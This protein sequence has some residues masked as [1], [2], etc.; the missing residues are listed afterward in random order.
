M[1]FR[2]F[3]II[4]FSISFYSNAENY[5]AE[6]FFGIFT[7]GDS[8]AD[9]ESKNKAYGEGLID[10]LQKQGELTGFFDQPSVDLFK[11]EAAAQCLECS[12]A[13][14]TKD[15]DKNLQDVCRII[16]SSDACKDVN[17]EDLINCNKW[18]ESKEFDTYNLIASCAQ[19]LF[20]ATKDLLSFAWN[21]LKV[22]WDKTIHPKETAE[23]S[24]AYVESVRLY[25]IDIYDKAYDKENPPLRSFKAAK[26][27]STEITQLLFKTIQEYLHREYQVFGC[28]NFKARSDLIC[29]IAASILIPP[30]TALTI[31][32]NSS[33]I[34]RIPVVNKIL[35]KSI[36][37]KTLARKVKFQT[38]LKRDLSR[39]EMKALNKALLVGK[40]KKGKNGQL[41]KPGNYT[42][43]QIR[44]KRLILEK[45]KFSR[46]D[47]DR[48][49][50]F[51]LSFSSTV[52]SE[53]ASGLRRNH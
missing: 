29:K 4:L 14:K 40:G 11:T 49:L 36:S 24:A 22:T 8:L 21:V 42:V 19:G 5:H 23:E 41:A 10:K 16:V 47:I 25:L 52:F 7:K 31:L 27:I 39:K 18:S 48:F 2:L 50:V 34:G 3:F 51:G 53:E 15:L 6:E 45:A 35:K 46:K 33:K 9:Q 13:F 44:K 17:K 20:D 37:K 12:G 38:V 30:I 43:K 1:V 32:K 26:K 28:L